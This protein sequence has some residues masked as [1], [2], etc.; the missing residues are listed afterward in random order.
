M[1][2]RKD[3]S[4]FVGDVEKAHPTVSDSTGEELGVRPQTVRLADL[5]SD[6]VRL[7]ERARNLEAPKGSTSAVPLLDDM[8]GILQ[9][10]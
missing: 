4:L 2:K 6:Y 8:K 3:F 7:A 10:D 5:W 1:T 9:W